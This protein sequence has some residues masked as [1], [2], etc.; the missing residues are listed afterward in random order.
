[1][2]NS[3]PHIA[4]IL[5][6]GTITM[7]KGGG[8]GIAPSLTA[9]ALIE[10]VPGLS[11]VAQ[12]MPSSPFRIPGASLTVPQLGQVASAARAAVEDGAAGVIVVQGT[13]TIEETAFVLDCLWTLPAPLIVTGAMRGASALSA[14]GPA[15]IL[16]AVRTAASGE[17]IGK[18]VTVCLGDR[19][20]AAW[21]VTKVHT[22]NP[23]TFRDL[24]YGSIGTVYGSRVEYGRIPVKHKKIHTDRI[25]ED[26]WIITCWSGMDGGIV[27][28]TE[29]KAAGL[30]IDGIGCGNVPPKCREAVLYLREKGM[31]IVLTTR[32]PS[33]SVEEEY[34]YEGSALSM[35]DSGIILGGRLS[36][37]KARLLLAL[38]M[39][40]TKNI[41]EIKSCF[42]GIREE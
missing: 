24:H 40:K 14:D 8:G 21:D 6:G 29:G 9:E 37:W 17:S 4:L 31:P 32:V 16:A 33:G 12:V 36:S 35:K 5:L 13:D 11:G 20:Y 7:T 19:I 30:V 28:G 1:M 10:A 18:G 26:I 42:L 27:Y 25:E 38:A 39:G 15:N 3:L 23:D 41:E 2:T 22:T 34:S